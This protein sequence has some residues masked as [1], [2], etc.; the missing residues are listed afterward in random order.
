MRKRAMTKQMKKL[1][2]RVRLL[3]KKIEPKH[4]N[5]HDLHLQ[6]DKLERRFRDATRKIGAHSDSS[7]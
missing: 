3:E 1:E 5:V 4:H 7:V 2:S 6:I